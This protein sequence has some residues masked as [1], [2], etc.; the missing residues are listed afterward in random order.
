MLPCGIHPCEIKKTKEEID[1]SIEEIR[2][3][4]KEEKIVAIGEI[5]A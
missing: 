4:A 2:N 5:R 3:I 1:K